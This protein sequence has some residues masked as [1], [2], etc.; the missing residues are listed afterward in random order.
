MVNHETQIKLG[1]CNNDPSTLDSLTSRLATADHFQRWNLYIVINISD[2]WWRLCTKIRI[3]RR[4]YC[5]ILSD[6]GGMSENKNVDTPGNMREV[7]MKRPHCMV[8]VLLP[9]FFIIFMFDGAFLVW[10]W[11]F[12]CSGCGDKMWQSK[13]LGRD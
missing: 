7:R 2:D 4:L 8:G 9:Q 11:I 12:M 10:M 5:E 3:S 6:M 13:M 1:C